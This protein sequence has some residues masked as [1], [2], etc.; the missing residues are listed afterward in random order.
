M[1]EKHVDGDVDQYAVVSQALL[2][3]LAIDAQEIRQNLISFTTEYHH[4]RLI[5]RHARLQN[6]VGDLNSQLLRRLAAKRRHDL[7]LRYDCR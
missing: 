5:A 2:S 7:Q 3:R 6:E 4:R 1:Q